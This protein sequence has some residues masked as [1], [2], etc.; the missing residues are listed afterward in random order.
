MKYCLTIDKYG[1]LQEHKTFQGFNNKKR[2]L[3]R[4]QY[5]NMIGGKKYQLYYL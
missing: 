1:I 4:S 2:L 3:Y 5:F